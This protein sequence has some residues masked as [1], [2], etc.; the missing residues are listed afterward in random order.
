M[1]AQ[2]GYHF[3][4]AFS[5]NILQILFYFSFIITKA[6][7]FIENPFA[8]YI[9]FILYCDSTLSLVTEYCVSWIDPLFYFDFLQL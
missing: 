5:T 1:S 2:H 9:F 3:R 7:V 8:L 6:P 4:L